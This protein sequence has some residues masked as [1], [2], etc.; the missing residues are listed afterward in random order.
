M[1]RVSKR[2]VGAGPIGSSDGMKEHDALDRKERTAVL[3]KRSV[4][5]GTDMLEQP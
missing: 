1:W 2:S 5:K 4:I 3:E